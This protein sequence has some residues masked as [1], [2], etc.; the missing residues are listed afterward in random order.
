MAK[1]IIGISG[2]IA[3]GK[4]TVANYI[5]EKYGAKQFKFSKVLRDILQRIYQEVSRDNLQKLSLL[6]RQMFG[7]DMLA[8]VVYNDILNTKEDIIVIDG[9]RRLPDIEIL[10]PIEGFKLFFIDAVIGTRYERIIQ[11]SENIDDRN[12]TFETFKKEE[13]AETEIYIDGLKNVSDYMID[14]NSNIDD[15]HKQ[16]DNIILN[17]KN[18]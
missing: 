2:R 5:I 6:L 14:N 7:D 9:V 12:K 3:S 15:L 17:L 16:I 18:S 8:K 11:R 4:D 1:I 10:K 13:E